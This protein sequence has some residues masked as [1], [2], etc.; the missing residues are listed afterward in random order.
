ML[1]LDQLCDL[2][3]QEQIETVVVGFTDHY[4]RLVGKRFDAD[5]F[6]EEISSLGTHGCDY[7]LTTDMEMEP[8]PGYQF[9]NWDLGYG[10][11]HIVPDLTTLRLA[12][13]L[14]KS[15]L[16]LCD[17]RTE[18]THADVSIGPRSVLRA[19]VAAA[20]ELGF[21]T[22]A[23]SELEYFLFTESYRRAAEQ[24]YRDLSPAGWYLEDYHLLQGA[25]TE[26]FTAA[27]RHHL[28]RSGVPVENSKGEWGLGQHELNIRHADVLEMADRHVVFKQCLKEIADRM[29][30]RTHLSGRADATSHFGDTTLKGRRT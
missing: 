7:L 23:A 1:T 9:A 10:D 14:D 21:D 2:A 22:A 27:V 16:V 11:F 20:R 29:I 4:G 30:L 6:V 8:V 25:R 15:A 19:Q 18:K 12:S 5:L 13:W 3:A 17:V 28:K 26:P 24:G